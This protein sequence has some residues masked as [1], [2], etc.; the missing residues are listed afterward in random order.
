ME[1]ITDSHYT[2]ARKIVSEYFRNNYLEM[3]IGL[4]QLIF[5][6]TR[7]SRRSSLETDQSKTRCIN[8]Y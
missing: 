8:R 1:D 5:F 7:I 6:H 3:Y 4:I 2:H